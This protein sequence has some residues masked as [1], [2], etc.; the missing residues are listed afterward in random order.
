MRLATIA[1]A[2]MA[3]SAVATHANEEINTNVQPEV[4]EGVRQQRG[5]SPA[6]FRQIEEQN[7]EYD[8]HRDYDARLIQKDETVNL[9]LTELEVP[10]EVEISEGYLTT[11]TFLDINGNPYPVRVSRVGNDTTFIV[12][13]GTGDDCTID[14]SDL[15][16]AHILTVG[17]PKM[18]GRSNLRVFF[19]GLHRA[20]QIPL[21]ART[22]SYHEEVLVMLP[23]ENPDHKASR[24]AQDSRLSLPDT[25]D[26]YARALLDGIS[27]DRMHGATELD[28]TVRNRGGQEQS[29]SRHRAIHAE[30]NTYLKTM[31]RLPNPSATAKT[32]GSMRMVVYR[33]KGKPRVITGQDRDGR[34]LELYLSA[35]E[36]VLGYRELETDGR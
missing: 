34:I 23:I 9:S 26:A 7:R 30:G 32:S 14:E 35:P 20:V 22:D 17:T 4:E 21:V 19:R 25:D 3:L 24:M 36:H 31:I 18:A 10:F 8:R 28:V 5:G 29:D 16:I 13:A 1:T 11:L 2:L 15:D 33:F 6:L 27:V 12:C